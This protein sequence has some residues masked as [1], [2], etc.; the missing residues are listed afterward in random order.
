M[1]RALRVQCETQHKI[2]TK[3]K[4]WYNNYTSVHRYRDKP[5]K[6]KKSS[7]LNRGPWLV[8]E[9]PL[10]FRHRTDEG[11]CQ[12][13]KTPDFRTGSNRIGKSQ[14]KVVGASLKRA[15]LAGGRCSSRPGSVA[16]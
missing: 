15:R 1:D 2:L 5:S 11:V 4:E 13:T 6:G 16:V 9:S 12:F 14:L 3:L 10:D 8:T 7:G